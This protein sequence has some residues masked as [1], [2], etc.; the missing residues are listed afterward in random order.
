MSTREIQEAS[1]ATF[2]SG[3]ID[4]SSPDFPWSLGKEGGQSCILLDPDTVIRV[5]PMARQ[6]SGWNNV[7]FSPQ[8]RLPLESP[9][10]HGMVVTLEGT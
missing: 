4:A 10:G 7:H 5:A 1:A 2:A 9:V 6:Y 8:L 3:T